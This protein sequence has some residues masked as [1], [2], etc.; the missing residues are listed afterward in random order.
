MSGLQD[1][2]VSTSAT[3]PY[4]PRFANHNVVKSCYL[5]YVKFHNCMSTAEDPNEYCCDLK[6]K[7]QRHCALPQVRFYLDL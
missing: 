2:L 4:D 5:Y 7:Y 3:I 1:A 6:L